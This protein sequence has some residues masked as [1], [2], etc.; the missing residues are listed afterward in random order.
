MDKSEREI[1]LILRCR[2]FKL[3][4]SLLFLISHLFPVC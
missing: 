3:I 2:L 4:L 1:S